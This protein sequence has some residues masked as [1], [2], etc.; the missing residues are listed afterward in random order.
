MEKIVQSLHKKKKFKSFFIRNFVIIT[1][2]D[3]IS[4]VIILSVSVQY[5]VHFLLINT[6]MQFIVYVSQNLRHVYEHFTN[7]CKK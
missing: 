6:Y 4:C 5:V 3:A 2:A 1:K 7:F